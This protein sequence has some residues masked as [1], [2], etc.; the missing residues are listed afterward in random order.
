MRPL[1]QAVPDPAGEPG[2]VG[3]KA[4]WEYEKLA[5]ASMGRPFTAHGNMEKDGLFPYSANGFPHLPYG[6]AESIFMDI[7]FPLLAK[8]PAALI[9]FSANTVIGRAQNGYIRDLP[10]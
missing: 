2:L 9:F 10:R 4:S 7:S 1:P 6:T 8:T 3:L 5:F